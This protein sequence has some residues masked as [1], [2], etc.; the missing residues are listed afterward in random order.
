MEL[1]CSIVDAG[2]NET[3][4]VWKPV[5]EDPVER[6]KITRKCLGVDPGCDRSLAAEQ[7]AFVMPEKNDDQ[8]I[9]IEMGGGEFCGNA[10]RAVA[11]LQFTRSGKRSPNPMLVHVSGMK[12]PVKCINNDTGR[13]QEVIVEAQ[14]RCAPAVTHLSDESTLVQLHGIAHI[15]KQIHPEPGERNV[16]EYGL[17]DYDA[18]IQS[19][20]EHVRGELA[21]G[22]ILFQDHRR[23]HEIKPFVSVPAIPSTK[24]ETA[25]A[26]GS[27]AL[28]LVLNGE[29]TR[30]R[31]FQIFQPSQCPYRIGM[32]KRDGGAFL[33]SLL[34]KVEVRFNQ[35]FLTV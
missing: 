12:E 24:V 18:L 10:A 2:G 30:E 20:G 33:L 31:Y 21:Y 26:S 7:V 23:G 28:A 15:V 35:I 11:A 16:E 9:H 29:G 14:I 17:P 4:V 22:L 27:L 3:L 13:Y 32:L 1:D 5:V 25:C 19:Y 6:A 8:E 34:S